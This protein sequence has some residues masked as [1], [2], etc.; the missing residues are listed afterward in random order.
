M[1]N[2][3]N[4]MQV[5]KSA[6]CKFITLKPNSIMLPGSKLVADRFEAKFHYAI[7]FEPDRVMEFGHRPAS[8]Y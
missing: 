1:S 7:W 3:V 8:S 2:S 6:G 4:Q 5:P